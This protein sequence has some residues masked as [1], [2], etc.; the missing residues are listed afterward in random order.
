MRKNLK[1]ISLTSML[2]GFTFLATLI[3]INTGPSTY[4]NLSEVIVFTSSL[5]FGPL[6]GGLSGGVGAALADILLGFALPWA[7]ISFLIKGVEGLIVGGISSLKWKNRTLGDVI[8]I[9]LVFPIMIGGY[10]LSVGLLY[11]WPASLIEF[12]TDIVQCSAGLALALPLT[13]TL[14][15]IRISERW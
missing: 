6:V 9:L 4:F 14:R 11:G 2:A 8:S 5:L 15:K 10:T 7:P 13:Y 1:A 12:Y 3:H